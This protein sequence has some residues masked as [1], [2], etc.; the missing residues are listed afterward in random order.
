MNEE[1]R[2][3]HLQANEAQINTAKHEGHANV[4][5]CKASLDAIELGV[6]AILDEGPYKE[7]LPFLIY[8]LTS[9]Y[10]ANG[11]YRLLRELLTEESFKEFERRR[12]LLPRRDLN[13]RKS[14]KEKVT[15]KETTSTEN[16][17]ST[18]DASE[19]LPRQYNNSVNTANS[20]SQPDN[21]QACQNSLNHIRRI[22]AAYSSTDF[23]DGSLP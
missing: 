3:L 4:N 16:N 18:A 22:H 17:T 2:Q 7:D 6:D 12:K 21:N 20:N 15:I 11:D 8:Q 14:Q 5:E 9:G 1:R 10:I 19:E 23:R 13:T